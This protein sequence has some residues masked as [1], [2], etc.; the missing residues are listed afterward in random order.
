MKRNCGWV[1]AAL[2]LTSEAAGLAGECCP[3]K[4][5][6]SCCAAAL[7]AGGA[8]G[9]ESVYQLDYTW[10]NDAGQAVK[11]ASLAGRPQLVVMFFA[12][13]EYAC[14][15]LVYQVQQI[16]AA[17]PEKLR[18]NLGVLLV[19]FDTQRDSV[20]ALRQYRTQHGLD[21]NRWALLRG[22]ADG[23][24]ELAAVLGVQFKQDARG[25]F[26]H[27]NRITLLNSTG[28]IVYQKTGLDFNAQP[29]V[30]RVTTL[31]AR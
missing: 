23:V 8:P 14:P 21:A 20:A 5:A 4:P 12:Q 28:E 7:P 17:L 2:L 19:S 27:S 29:L 24:R 3:A 26:S 9:D 16:E 22:S 25:Q 11:L 15:L 13:C 18:A 31:V 30:Q 10:T 1:M 6:G